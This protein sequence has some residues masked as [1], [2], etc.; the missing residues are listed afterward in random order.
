LVLTITTT[1]T[2]VAAFQYTL[3]GHTFSLT[4]SFVAPSPASRLPVCL[5]SSAQCTPVSSS[6]STIVPC[7]PPL[8]RLSAM[9]KIARRVYDSNVHQTPPLRWNILDFIRYA[10]VLQCRTTNTKLLLKIDGLILQHKHFAGDSH[11]QK[12][13]EDRLAMKTVGLGGFRGVFK[14]IY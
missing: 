2:A 8:P 10:Y 1:Y 11:S 5:S 4:D 3:D 14:T 13:L 7:S 6:A 9:R 12:L